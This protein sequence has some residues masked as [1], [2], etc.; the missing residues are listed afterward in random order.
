MWAVLDAPPT[1]PMQ[2]PRTGAIQPL[3]ALQTMTDDDEEMWDVLDEMERD[4]DAKQ[5]RD[6]TKT[7]PQQISSPAI[8]KP[9]SPPPSAA[10][11][12]PEDDDTLDDMYM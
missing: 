1:E 5:K 4:S 12:Q 6:P 3:P 8:V 7:S 2:A 9:L 11:P 10:A